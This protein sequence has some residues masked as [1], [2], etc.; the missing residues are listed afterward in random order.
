MD[1]QPVLGGERVALRP[2]TPD[3]REPLFAVARDR[4]I[5]AMHPAH[6]RWQRPVFD[7]FFDEGLAAGGALTLIDRADGAIIGATRYGP[8]DPASGEIEIGWTYLAR[9]HWRTGHNREAKRLMLAHIFR[10]AET[11]VFHVGEDNHRS[12]TAVEALGAL[13]RPGRLLIERAGVPAPHIVYALAR[14]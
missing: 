11:V 4:E 12:R 3:D 5:W 10:W 13:A 14:P 7:T 2:S 6:D 9:S 1:R 8:F